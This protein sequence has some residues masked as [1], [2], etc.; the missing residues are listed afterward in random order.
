[1]TVY[2]ATKEKHYDKVADFVNS[3]PDDSVWWQCFT[4][5]KKWDKDFVKW[6]KKQRETLQI[7][8][9]E[10]NDGNIR[11]IEFCETRGKHPKEPKIITNAIVLMDEND[12]ENEERTYMAELLIEAA[13]THINKG[14]N[15]A[16]MLIRDIDLPYLHPDAEIVK[17]SDLPFGAGKVYLI[18]IDLKKF[19]GVT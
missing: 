19:L 11:A 12:L 5:G 6:I 13:E 18:R 10:D 15:I 14:Y 4:K 8:A 9:C 7:F 3:Q 16:E 1:M 17:E 2:E